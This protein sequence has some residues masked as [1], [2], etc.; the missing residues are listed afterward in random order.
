MEELERQG[1]KVPNIVEAGGFVQHFA[2]N[3]HPYILEALGSP[4]YSMMMAEP[5]WNQIRRSYGADFSGYGE[6]LPDQHFRTYGT[7][8]SGMPVELGGEMPGERN[9]FAGAPNE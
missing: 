2:T 4:L 1:V 6:I 7:G 3:P 5:Y 8:F 9:R